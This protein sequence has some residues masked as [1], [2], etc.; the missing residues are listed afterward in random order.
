MIGVLLALLIVPA[1]AGLACFALPARAAGGLTVASGLTGFALVLAVVPAAAHHDL[2]YLS[3]LRVDA[4]S[5]IF[6]LATGFLYGAVAVYAVCYLKGHQDRR[7]YAGLNLFAWAML[8]APL[9]SSLALL[10]IAVEVTTIFGPC[11]NFEPDR[12]VRFAAA[13]DDESPQVL[14]LVPKGYFAGDGNRDWEE[15]VKNSVREVKSKHQIAGPGRHTLR[16]WMVD[17]GVAL[18]K[19]VVNTG[20]LRPSYL[21]PPESFRR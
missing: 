11:L 17:P 19:I 9:M 15:S 1:A 5:A 21:G 20:G 10:W 4:V 12:G 2:S 8:A 3:Y 16:L 13:F 14:T 6:L 18:Q 7:F